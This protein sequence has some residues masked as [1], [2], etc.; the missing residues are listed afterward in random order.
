MMSKGM[1]AVPPALK[2]GLYSGMALLPLED[3]AEYEK[4]RRAVFD[5]YK[6]NGPSELDTIDELSSLF[7]RKKHLLIYKLAANVKLKRNSFFTHQEF[8]PPSFVPLVPR[9]RL[10]TPE[11]MQE[12]DRKAT[13]RAKAEL[14]AWLE[15]VEI[16]E[17]ATIEYLLEELDIIEPINGMI[18]R[19]I[20]RLL[21]IRGAKSLSESSST[22][23]PLS[24]GKKAA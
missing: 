18:D 5:E 21:M 23:I 15:L 1:K 24:R 4:H 9:E 22:N 19:C 8:S 16:G 14:G 6:P 12:L 13:E 7:W 20:K 11:Q 17:I 10:H 2:H 3:E